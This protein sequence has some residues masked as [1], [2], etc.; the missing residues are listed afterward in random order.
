MWQL[1]FSLTNAIAL[2]GWLVLLALPRGPL[3]RAV[4]IYL[5][6]GLLCLAYAI[7][8]VMM[9]S[10]AVDPQALVPERP[11]DLLDYT[12]DGLR[13]LFMSDG[14]M[15]I[16]W[17]HYLALDLLAGVWVAGEADARG[18]KRIWQVPMLLLTFLS[19]PI[20]VLVWLLVRPWRGLEPPVETGGSKA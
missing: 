11:A 10:G 18:V 4:P 9:A 2:F 16:G 14:G 1:L 3:L 17:T 8:V 6:V 12:I 15:V 5:G 20:G 13:W 19:G 7:L